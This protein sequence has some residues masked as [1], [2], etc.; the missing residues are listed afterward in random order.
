MATAPPE[1]ASEEELIVRQRRQKRM[2]SNRES[3]RRSRLR[4]QMQLEKLTT[5]VSWLRRDKRQL[6]AILCVAVQHC[7]AMEADNAVLRARVAELT[8]A[9][10]ALEQILLNV[11][12]TACTGISVVDYS[13]P[14]PGCFGNYYNGAFVTT[15]NHQLAATEEEA[16]A[17][18]RVVMPSADMFNYC[19]KPQ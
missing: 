11:S 18:A 4:K 17:A 6:V 7:A 15:A 2:Q 14:L 1:A 9:L 19:L 13:I 10:E 12:G 16:A 8:A 5:E 3:A